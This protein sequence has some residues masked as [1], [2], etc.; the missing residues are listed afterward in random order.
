MAAR[1]TALASGSAGNACLVE[2]DGFGVLLDFGLGPRT[3]AGRMAARGLSWRQVGLALLTHTH[4]DHWRETTFVHLARLGIPLCCHASHA[5]C[6]VGQSDGFATLHSA[7]LVRFYEAC[8][9]IQ[10]GPGL[11]AVPLPV[12]HDAGETFGFRFEGGHGLF[13]PGWALGYA[14]DLGCWDNELARSLADVDLLALEFNHDEHLQRTS[15]RPQY[16]IRR[17][18]GDRG[19][20]SNSQAAELLTGVLG[21]SVHTRPRHVVPLHLSR[22]CNRPELAETAAHDVLQ[23]VDRPAGV[24]IAPQYEPGPTLTISGPAT[25]VKSRRRPPAA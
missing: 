10:L 13:G 5:E 15:G 24:A 3:I 16:L 4:G 12:S 17:V 11:V 18:L 7:G 8:R 6:F 22:E 1:F 14:A 2:A 20:L 25:P 23:R 21:E 9:P 19:H